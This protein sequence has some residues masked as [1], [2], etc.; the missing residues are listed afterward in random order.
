MG[1]REE[2]GKVEYHYGFYGAVRAEYEPTNVKMEYLQEHELGNE[3][4]RMDMLIL[5]HDRT[6]LT[7]PIGSFFKT[8]NVLEYKSPRDSLS[9]DDFYKAQGYALIYKGMGKTIDAVPV[10]ELTVSLF[11]HVYPRELF[12]KLKERGFSIDQVHPG[13]YHVT[14][15]VSVPAQVVITS[16]LP[17]GKYEAFRALAKD[18]TKEDMMKLLQLVEADEDPMMVEYIRAVLNVSIALNAALFD[19]IKKEG[20]MTEAINKIFQKEFAKERNEGRQEGFLE[21]LSGLVRDG[22]LSIADAAKRAEMSISEF[23]TKTSGLKPEK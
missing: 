1:A 15:A 10:E 11:R 17:K 4:I 16:R 5:K 20:I 6:P 13:V 8:H 7:D 12:A 3:P 21:A 9:I 22:I 14:G 18:V 23:Q 2:T 19:E